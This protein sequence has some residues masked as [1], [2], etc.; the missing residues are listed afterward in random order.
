MNERDRIEML[1]K[2][3]ELSP[4]QFA[5]KTGIQRASI[6]HIL[7]GRNKPSLEVMLKIFDAFPGIDMKWLMTGV[8]EEP[9]NEVAQVS[10]GNNLF[11]EEDLSQHYPVNNI[12]EHHIAAVVAEQARQQAPL[13]SKPVSAKPQRKSVQGRH[14]QSQHPLQRKIKEV[15]IYYTDGTYETLLP[16]KM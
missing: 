15:R 2:C 12:P 4:S 8:G 13:P 9:V 10:T 6:S 16:E 1:M 11:P 14:L 3:Y 7:S 5:D